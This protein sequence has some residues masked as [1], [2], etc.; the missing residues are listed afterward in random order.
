MQRSRDSWTRW[1]Q[2]R[3]T[4]RA[5]RRRLRME[6]LLSELATLRNQQ[7]ALVAQV[8]QLHQLQV[9]TLLLVQDGLQVS[10]SLQLSSRLEELKELQLETLNSLQPSS[11]LAIAQQI[12][13]QKSAPFVP[14]S[15]S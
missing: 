12:G 9:K 7:E 5:V 3:T 8:T 14:S 15:S 6:P 1:R 4:A 10:S 13:L 2:S 11:T